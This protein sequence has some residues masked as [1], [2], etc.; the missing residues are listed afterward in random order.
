MI[1]ELCILLIF[2]AAYHFLGIYPAIGV[3]LALYT[4]QIGLQWLRRKPISRLELLTYTSVILLGTL[5]LIFRNELF[6]KWKPSV[7]YFLCASGIIVARVWT[8]TPTLQKILGHTMSLPTKIWAQL[9]Y[10]WC[11]FLISLAVLNLFIAYQF[12]TDL[13]VYFKLFGTMGLLVIFMGLQAYWLLPY[14]KE[15]NAK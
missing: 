5:S 9:D 12:S 14:L 1:S 3:A 8:Q 10:I 7:I 4:V 15:G 6:F 11:A 2:F 13:W